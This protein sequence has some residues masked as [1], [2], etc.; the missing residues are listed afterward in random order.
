MEHSHW[1]RLVLERQTKY[2]SVHYRFTQLLL[3]LALVFSGNL[4]CAS[5]W[6]QFKEWFWTKNPVEGY[7]EAYTPAQDGGDIFARVVFPTESKCNEALLFLGDSNS[8]PNKWKVATITYG[9]AEYSYGNGSESIEYFQLSKAELQHLKK[10]NNLK[11]FVDNRVY[12]FSLRGSA[13]AI[14]AA[15]AACDKWVRG[16]SSRADDS[17]ASFDAGDRV[18]DTPPT[19]ESFSLDTGDRV[20]DTSSK[21]LG[22]ATLALWFLLLALI[23]AWLFYSQ[24]EQK[25]RAAQDSA[26]SGRE[27]AERLRQHQEAESDRNDGVREARQRQEEQEALRRQQAQAR[28]EREHRERER[29]DYEQRR[30]R[31]RLEERERKE[32]EQQTLTEQKALHEETR[33]TEEDSP[34]SE[35]RRDVTPHRASNTPTTVADCLRLLGVDK[36]ASAEVITE[37][38]EARRCTYDPDRVSRLGEE[39]RP[40][41]ETLI[42]KLE[43]AMRFLRAK[44][45][46]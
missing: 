12:R 32:R 17:I 43:Q 21:E 4:V 2:F 44:G 13:A 46:V 27:Q 11:I 7:A 39:F 14:T 1:N 37:A 34:T 15:W 42:R 20:G 9:D 29:Q 22:D 3:A 6:V 30:Q 35:A 31:Q 18:G 23:A 28:N 36:D 10:R 41:A 16:Q 5:D 38:Y 25:R 40:A 26:L 19:V 8:N 24:G 33:R 45:R